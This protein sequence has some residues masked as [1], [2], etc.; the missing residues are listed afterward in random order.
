MNKIKIHV[1]VKEWH[2]Q[3]RAWQT[4][5]I[6]ETIKIHTSNRNWPSIP[7]A[8]GTRGGKQRGRVIHRIARKSYWIHINYLLKLVI[9][10][11]RTQHHH[12]HHHHQRPTFNLIL[13]IGRTIHH[14]RDTGY[15][16]RDTFVRFNILLNC[17]TCQL[18][19]ADHR[20]NFLKGFHSNLLLSF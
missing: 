14:R 9:S 4:R 13:F 19:T 6:S 17:S 8:V 2:W 18:D 1:G 11:E 12:I 5:R 7:A 20:I 3:S 10:R 16:I 15:G